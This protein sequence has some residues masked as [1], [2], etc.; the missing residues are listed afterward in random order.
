MSKLRSPRRTTLRK[1]R[2]MQH[3]YTE[4]YEGGLR[5]ELIYQQLSQEFHVEERTV[6]DNL[7]FI[8]R[9]DQ[10]HEKRTP[11]D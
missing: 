8:A 5:T 6:V 11:Q 9:F 10:E 4:L 2:A 3:R 7:A 1:Y